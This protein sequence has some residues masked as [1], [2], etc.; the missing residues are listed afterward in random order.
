MAAV[1]QIAVIDGTANGQTAQPVYLP[2]KESS[3]ASKVEA[4]NAAAEQGLGANTPEYKKDTGW[5]PW[6]SV[7]ASFLQLAICL[8]APNAYGVYQAE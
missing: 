2:D 7:I 8:G 6:C 4:G 3:G 1:P 5:R